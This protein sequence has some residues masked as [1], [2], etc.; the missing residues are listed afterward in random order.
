MHSAFASPSNLLPQPISNDALYAC[1]AVCFQPLVDSS[2]WNLPLR[3]FG[4]QILCQFQGQNVKYHGHYWSHRAQMQN[5]WWQQSELSHTDRASAFVV[6][7]LKLS[8]H[9]V[10]STRKIWL[11]FFILCAHVGVPKIVNARDSAPLRWGVADPL[12]TRSYPMC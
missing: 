10:W 7:R 4:A 11:L 8:S 3:P 1:S 9:L 6:I 2:L 5:N 12:E